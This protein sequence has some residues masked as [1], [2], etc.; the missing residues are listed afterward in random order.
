MAGLPRVELTPGRHE[1]CA[2]F[3]GLKLLPRGYT[4]DLGIH[5]RDGT[6]ADLVTRALD[7]T[8]LRMAES[9]DDH[10]P[11]PQTRGLV[12]APAQWGLSADGVMTVGDVPGQTQSESA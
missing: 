7:F 12:R 4:I 1:W 6:T 9:G 5:H 2:T 8:V 10:Y 3:E 11:W